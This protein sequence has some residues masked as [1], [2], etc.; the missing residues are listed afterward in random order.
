MSTTKS[1]SKYC[2]LLVICIVLPTSYY[3]SIGMEWW[4][5][6]NYISLAKSIANNGHIFPFRQKGGKSPFPYSGQ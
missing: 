3:M 5:Q 1:I 4:D 2:I 6:I